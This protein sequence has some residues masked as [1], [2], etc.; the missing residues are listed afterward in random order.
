MYDHLD[1]LHLQTWFPLNDTGDTTHTMASYWLGMSRLAEERIEQPW[2]TIEPVV[3]PFS[4]TGMSPADP[5]YTYVQPSGALSIPGMASDAERGTVLALYT[6]GYSGGAELPS[7]FIFGDGETGHNPDDAPL[8]IEGTHRHLSMWIKNVTEDARIVVAAIVNTNHR[9]DLKVNFVLG[10]TPQVDYGDG[11]CS[12]HYP[13]PLNGDWSD[14]EWHYF[15]GDLAAQLKPGETLEEINAVIVRCNTISIDDLMFAQGALQKAYALVPGDPRG[16]LIGVQAGEKAA[17]AA[18]HAQWWPLTNELGTVLATTDAAGD[19]IGIY[20]PDLSGNYR[21]VVGERPDLIGITNKPYYP[22]LGLYYYGARWYD[23]QRGRW[24]SEE[25]LGLDGPN[26]Y[27]FAFNKSS[28]GIDIHGFQFGGTPG[29]PPYPGGPMI[30]DESTFGLRNRLP[31]GDS[32]IPLTFGPI[33][34]TLAGLEAQRY[35]AD[36]VIDPNSSILSYS[37][38]YTGGVLSS[39]WTPCTAFDTGLTLGGGYLSRVGVAAAGLRVEYGA[40]KLHW[41]R[42]RLTH[43]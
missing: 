5:W 38:A 3:R 27:H 43:L 18:G 35:Y 33:P 20:Q 32:M 16:G 26:M 30:D 1:R 29:N 23:P 39:L 2:W 15:E 13:A 41:K 34:G 17:L 37:F 11:D 6:T 28:L 10:G 24:M 19:T 21:T 36:M 22:E 40:W 14:G 4:E 25:P 9:T 8:A 31:S 12:F 7:S 42:G